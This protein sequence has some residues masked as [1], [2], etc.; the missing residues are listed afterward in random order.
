MT[1]F[2]KQELGD[3]IKTKSEK[4]K[5]PDARGVS[6]E[7][8]K[9]S[10]RVSKQWL[11]LYIEVFKPREEIHAD[12]SRVNDPCHIQKGGGPPSP[13]KYPTHL[14][15]LYLVRTLQR[16]PLQTTS[17]HVGRLSISCLLVDR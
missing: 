13:S 4:G 16:T 7:M 12:L 9:H 1:L 2:T 6:A 8:I 5:A 10:N 11:H 15:D 14:F 17:L 3:V